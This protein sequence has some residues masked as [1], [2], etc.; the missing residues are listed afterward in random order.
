MSTIPLERWEALAEVLRHEAQEYGALVNLIVEEQNH[1][2][3]RKAEALLQ[4]LEKIEAQVAANQRVAK[5]RNE[6]IRTLSASYNL[7]GNT[8]LKDFVKFA[9]DTMY[10]LFDALAYEIRTLAERTHRL[11]KQNQF[12]LTNAFELSKSLLE[13][14]AVRR[15][16]VPTYDRN[17]EVAEKNQNSLYVNAIT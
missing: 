14:L 13:A 3:D 7:P 16:W 1:I 17:G 4:I 5:D 8:P 12:L 6:F 10:G 9:P 15:G 2:L 11:A